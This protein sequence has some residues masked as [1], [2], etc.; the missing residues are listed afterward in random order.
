MQIRGRPRLARLLQIRVSAAAHQLGK[1]GA[2]VRLRGQV[3][4][5]ELQIYR[6]PPM[7]CR[8]ALLLLSPVRAYS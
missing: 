7:L 3:Q 8:K 2:S 6:F 4:H 1:A 5:D